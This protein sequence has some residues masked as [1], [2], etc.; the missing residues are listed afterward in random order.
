MNKIIANPRE[1]QFRMQGMI[2]CLHSRANPRA[3]LTPAGQQYRSMSLLEMGREFLDLH[4]VETRS[5]SRFELSGALLHTRTH[6]MMTTGDFPS[7]LAS[8]A[9]KRLRESYTENP[10]SY[11]VWARRAPDAPDFKP[12]NVV[13]L[14]GAPDLLRTSEAGEFQYGQMK[15][16]G[17]TYSVLTY[18]RIVSLSRQAMVNDDLRAFDRMVAGFGAAARRLE[19]RLVYAQLTANGN[20]GDG[21]ALF[22]ATAVTTPG[23]HA[24]LQTGAGSALQASSLSTGRARMRVQAGLQSEEL[25]L[26]PSYLIVPAALEQTAYQLTSNQ[27][28]PAT[29]GAVNEFRQGGRTALTPVVETLL[30]GVSA[31]AWYL[32]ADTSQVDTVE[33][34]YLNGAEGPVIETEPGFQTDGISM[35]CRLDFAAKAIDYRGLHKAAGV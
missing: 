17:E 15:D 1:I 5:M 3:P 12:I 24:N 26:A 28:V 29:T 23:G 20:L 33:Y 9:S 18:G 13:Q 8:V 6:G 34:C 4:G 22:N 32:A 35:R 27:Y 16:S 11:S 25:S 10:P 2:D 30:D 19:N 7:L 31:T 14:S 21:G